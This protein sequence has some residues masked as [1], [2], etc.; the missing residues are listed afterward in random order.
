M[1]LLLLCFTS[2]LSFAASDTF[3]LNDALTSSYMDRK[4]VDVL[5]EEIAKKITPRIV[6]LNVFNFV[7]YKQ[8]IFNIRNIQLTYLKTVKNEKRTATG[9]VNEMTYNLKMDADVEIPNE[10]EKKD[11]KFEA[12]Q[13]VFTV[14]SAASVGECFVKV[15]EAKFTFGNPTGVTEEEW[16]TYKSL[17]GT[18]LEDDIK[19]SMET[20]LGDNNSWICA[21]DNYGLS[22]DLTSSYTDT[23]SIDVLKEEI[24]K[25][26]TPR[27]VKVN[28]FNK[29][30]REEIIFEMKNIQLTHQDTVKTSEDSGESINE[31][32]YNLKMDADGT[33]RKNGQENPEQEN[34]M[35]FESCTVVFTVNSAA[36]FGECFVKVKEAKFTFVNPTGV[37][38]EVWNTYKSLMGDDLEDEIKK[39]MQTALGT[40]KNWICGNLPRTF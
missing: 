3:G 40:K 14:N 25:K 36:S 33:I 16:N 6:K 27:I 4:D 39:S 7:H 20:A 10:E 23:K 28:V 26:I 15:K 12:S 37:T 5:K 8:I 35:N 18:S 38:E 17:M 13:V 32:T 2:L 21:S 19:K 22:D 34:T 29:K 30:T 1:V 11:M 24:A 9:E 31:M